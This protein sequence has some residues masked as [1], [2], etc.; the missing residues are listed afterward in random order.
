MPPQAPARAD[1]PADTPVPRAPGAPK[2]AAGLVAGCFTALLG[3]LWLAVGG[4]LCGPGLLWHR[5]GPRALAALTAGARRFADL[6][7]RRRSAFFGDRF[8]TTGAPSDEK[9]VGY[10]LRRTATGLVSA[11][12]VALLG[13]GA[14]L[15]VVLAAG[16]ARGDVGWA[17]LALQA[18]LGGVLL[19]LDVQG[20]RSLAAL[21]AR[22]ARDCF[23]LSERELLQR[24]IGELAASRA[25]VVTAVDTERRR[26]ERD[27]HD[28]LQQRLVALALLIARARRGHDTER[29]AAL[30]A[31]AHREVGDVLGELREVA[32][33]VYPSALDDLG[34]REA[35]GGVCDRCALPVHLS[36]EVPGPL[37]EA[38]E[39]AAYFVVS[40]AVTNTVKHAAATTVR[41]RLAHRDRRLTVRIEDDGKGGADPGGRGL[42]G[43]GG[44][45]AALDGTLTVDSPAGGPTII[46][47]ELP[48]V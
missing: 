19:F 1:P 22:L 12:V 18:G 45:V 41:L 42:T 37:P 20:L 46:T 16:V 17:D 30:L 10:L 39:T 33:R 24:R 28:G 4:L 7:R 2:R 48:C 34:L 9:I 47:A 8:P 40:E 35:L 13:F 31:Q 3:A 25:A 11:V 21:D 5:T 38:V 14:V 44:R 27:L 26:I 23:G 29:A 32:W 6:E 15:A 36:Y 43:L